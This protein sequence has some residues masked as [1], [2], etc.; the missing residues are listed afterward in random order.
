[1]AKV[2]TRARSITRRPSRPQARRSVSIPFDDWFAKTF[3]A[4]GET[5]RL[6]IMQVLPRQPIAEEMYSVVQ[7]AEELGL[8]QPTISHNLKI[9]SEASLVQCRRQ[10][11]SMYYYVDQESVVRWLKEVRAR[12]GCNHAE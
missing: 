12:F 5:T 7:L 2:T 3:A 6:R 1:M 9:L 11:N 10:C 4:L 8:K